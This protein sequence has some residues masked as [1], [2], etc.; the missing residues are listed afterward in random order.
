MPQAMPTRPR[1]YRG[2]TPTV[3]AAACL[4]AT[5]IAL[6]QST[7]RL[8]D[9]VDVNQTD[10]HIDV[11]LQFTCGMRYVAHDPSSQ[12]TLLRIRLIPSASCGI[13]PAA[14][15]APE[16]VGAADPTVIE[17]VVLEQL[18]AQELAL[19]IRWRREERFVLAPGADISGLRIRLLRPGRAQARVFINEDPGS[20]ASYAINLDS[21]LEPHDATALEL[22]R[23]RF[24]IAPYESVAALDGTR[25][26]RLRIGPFSSRAEAERVLATARAT[27]SRA[28]LA[29]G[30]ERREGAE[31]IDAA[32]APTRV[33]AQAAPLTEEALQAFMNQARAAM[34]NK[35]HAGAIN[36]LT[37]VVEQPEHAS[38]ADALELLGLARERSRHLAHAKAEYQEYLRLYPKHP[39]AARVRE[40]LRALVSATRRGADG[41]EIGRAH[42]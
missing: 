3:V 35:D 16:H 41:R 8:V 26:Y 24:G 27:Y 29:I 15:V 22:A 23:E 12:G 7:A 13:Q 14:T 21:S 36:A 25:W 1:Q 38:R 18:F 6:A 10:A 2:I 11:V 37:R 5:H 19:T 20:A 39:H 42:V 9:A 17:S 40:R 28:W 34:R 30:D 31:E 4:V 32:V 33:N